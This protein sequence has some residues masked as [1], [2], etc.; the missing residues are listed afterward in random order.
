MKNKRHA[1]VAV[2]GGGPA[3]YVGA[4]RAAQLGADVLVIERNALGG[5][6]MNKGCIPVKALLKSAETIEDVRRSKEFGV[7]SAVDDIRWGLA[8][9]RKGR[10]VKSLGLG[11]EQLMKARNIDV[12]KATGEVID[13][14]TVVI[15]N[16]DGDS[17][18][19]C[20][21]LIIATGSAQLWRMNTCGSASTAFTRR[22]M[23]SAG[24]FSRILPL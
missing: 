21:K 19:T 6:C 24:S 12:L 16:E 2:L 20:E 17:E 9:D 13:A 7:V 3:G 10:V 1:E 4:I 14:D 11:L 18:I 5:V 22:A 15:H 8:A 23:S